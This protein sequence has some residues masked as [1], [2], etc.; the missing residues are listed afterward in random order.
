[1]GVYRGFQT[2]DLIYY[3]LPHDRAIGNIVRVNN[4]IHQIV[5]EWVWTEPNSNW[6]VSESHKDSLHFD[7]FND[8]MPEIKKITEQEKLA[9]ILTYGT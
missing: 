6:F 4:K 5:V 3:Q 8:L 1:M 7:D 9:I 2:G